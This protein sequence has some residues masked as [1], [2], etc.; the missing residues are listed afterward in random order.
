M[1]LTPAGYASSVIEVLRG[2]FTDLTDPAVEEIIASAVERQTR[3][4]QPTFEVIVDDPR[5]ARWRL[6][7]DPRDRRRVRLAYYPVSPPG[8]PA[9][10]ALQQIVNDALRELEVT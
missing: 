2:R 7:A 8:S 4:P 1:P 5:S 6:K 3:D 10:N 9:G